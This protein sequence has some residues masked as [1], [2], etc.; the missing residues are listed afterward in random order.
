MT[1]EWVTWTIV[2]PAW[3]SLREQLHDLPALLGVQVAGRLVGEDQLRA[4]DDGP[5]HRHQ[6]LLAARE[7]VRV[8]V[9]LPDDLEAVERVAD[10][11]V[12]ARPS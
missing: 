8:E 11:R 1:S 12:A 5:R 10:D 9:L 4:G 3:F 7:L 6:L 2:V